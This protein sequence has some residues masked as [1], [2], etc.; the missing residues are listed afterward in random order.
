EMPRKAVRVALYLLYHIGRQ[1]LGRIDAGAVAGVDACLFDL[2]HDDGEY[3]V[4]VGDAI[5]VDLDCVLE[6]P[7]D[8]YGVLAQAR[9]ET[10]QVGSQ[11]IR[12]VYDTHTAPAEHIRRAYQHWKAYPRREGLKLVLAVRD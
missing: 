7:V 3:V 11:F 5:Y 10:L 2:L 9:A 8:Q 1:I 6:E 4:T 12:L